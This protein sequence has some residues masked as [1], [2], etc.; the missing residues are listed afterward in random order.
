MISTPLPTSRK[1]K[2]LCFFAFCN[3][4]L[5][6]CF[7]WLIQT[8]SSAVK[9]NSK[10]V[11]QLLSS[12]GSHEE[13]AKE[14]DEVE[15]NE[16][17][18]EEEEEEEDDDED[19]DEDKET[20][21]DDNEEEED[22]EE[23]EESEECV[24]EE[25]EEENECEEQNDH[26]VASVNDS[27]TDFESI[28]KPSVAGDPEM[29]ISADSQHLPGTNIP[30]NT[31]SSASNAD[32]SAKTQTQ[33][34]VLDC[35]GGTTSYSIPATLNVEQDCVVSAI[36]VESKF[37]DEDDSL[38]KDCIRSSNQNTPNQVSTLATIAL[39]HCTDILSPSMVQE[40]ET[41]KDDIDDGGDDSWSNKQNGGETV[42]NDSDDEED[43]QIGR[44]GR[45]T[46]LA[47]QRNMLPE[48][49]AQKTDSDSEL[50]KEAFKDDKHRSSWGSSIED[51]D[52]GLHKEDEE[53]TQ[54]QKDYV[55]ESESAI[56]HLKGALLQPNEN[57]PDPSSEKMVDEPKPT[58]PSTHQ[59]RNKMDESVSE[60]SQ[61]DSSKNEAKK[62]SIVTSQ[63]SMQ[64]SPHGSWEEENKYTER[65]S[66]DPSPAVSSMHD[67]NPINLDQNDVGSG[68]QLS[69]EIDENSENIKASDNS[70]DDEDE[71]DDNA[72]PINDKVAVCDDDFGTC[73]SPPTHLQSHLL[74][75]TGAL[76]KR[77]QE[78]AGVDGDEEDAHP[79]FEGS[80]ESTGDNKLVFVKN[81]CAT[82]DD[83]TND[84][85][86]GKEQTLQSGF[87][88]AK[89]PN[90]VDDS[91][92]T[93]NGPED[94]STE[95]IP[96]ENLSAI[97]PQAKILDDRE[98]ESKKISSSLFTKDDQCPDGTFFLDEVLP[99]TEIDNVDVECPD[100]TENIDMKSQE[101]RDFE[102]QVLQVKWKIE[103]VLAVV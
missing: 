64:Q 63:T 47:K 44:F 28:F 74:R 14:E 32:A 52:T 82:K 8:D 16:D 77:L 70:W 57:C 73:L 20:S 15:D 10:H 54:N 58:S 62:V 95:Y 39:K 40:K 36:R 79:Y 68:G 102:G 37:S 92:N 26:S 31:D 27:T 7:Y 65:E 78:E 101:Y 94:R 41:G 42:W 49:D 88:V 91:N 48:V 103:L 98:K 56:L 86:D 29:T 69:E 80:N 35:Q 12:K 99:Q 30:F 2:Y 25:D 18:E 67:D 4:F 83:E 17:E 5:Y 46:V 93:L 71:I 97:V 85:S 21:D 60:N 45:N 66:D 38:G 13:H 100:D 50:Q 22:D 51:S 43:N 61:W 9:G 75:P 84:D 34:A 24:S 89:A 11:K 53:E 6:F 1:V 76:D 3:L 59:S 33:T 19:E 72:K 87:A 96:L 55:L 23:E 90:V 81:D